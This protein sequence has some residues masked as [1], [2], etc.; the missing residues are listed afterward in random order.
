MKRDLEKNKNMKLKSQRNP[1]KYGF[2]TLL[3]SGKKNRFSS[4]MKNLEY[5][6][7]AIN[8]LRIVK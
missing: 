5:H 3:S 1:F 6:R 8:F 4:I 7:I 2:E